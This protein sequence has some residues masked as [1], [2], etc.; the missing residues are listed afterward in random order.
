MHKRAITALLSHK[1]RIFEWVCIGIVYTLLYWPLLNAILC[2]TLAGLWLLMAPKKF[3]LSTLP[4]KL[5]IL[6]IGL[7]LI[8]VIGLFYTENKKEGINTI[9]LQS[10]IL[11]FP[12]IF[13]TS[14]I[15]KNISVYKVLSHFTFATVSSCIIGLAI[16]L[17]RYS[18]SGELDMLTNQHLLFTPNSYPYIT[19]LFC[20]L[21]ITILL[22]KKQ[23]KYTISSILL[24]SIF[25]LLLSVRLTI[26]L[27]FVLMLFHLFKLA[28]PAIYRLLTIIIL[29]AVIIVS[30][31]SIDSL[32]RQFRE[33]TD[34]SANNTIALD[35]DASLGRGWGGKAIR[36][37]IWTCT[38]DVIQKHPIAGVGTG[39]IQD[40]LQQAYEDRKFYFASRYNR[41]NAH[42]QYLQTWGSN[43]L[44]G[45]LVLLGCLF[46]PLTLLKYPN[47]GALIYSIFLLLVS[48]NSLTEVMLDLNKGVIFYSFFNSIFAFSLLKTD[49]TNPK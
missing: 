4:G 45:L 35:Q 48:V 6:F 40:S 9:Q 31:L 3:D 16:A 17:F 20:L 27:W 14:P 47:E 12:V 39:D 37:A 19:G 8:E 25:I 18:Q 15:L 29:G 11:L 33:L 23:N 24:L 5:V 36:K 28:I 30:I 2:I 10:A 1:Y 41:Y 7:F 22:S 38:W 34:F 42:N 43:G 26:G 44:I 21:S 49:I 46:I 32:K 13:G